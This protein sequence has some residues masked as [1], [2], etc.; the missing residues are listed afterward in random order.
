MPT[1]P[2]C[3]QAILSIMGVAPRK[4]APADTG[5]EVPPRENANSPVC[6]RCEAARFPAPHQDQATTIRAD[7]LAARLRSQ[8]SIADEKAPGITE[9]K[10]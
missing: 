6:T 1:W 2:H 8:W 7:G 9:G 10:V 3:W 5:A 4:I